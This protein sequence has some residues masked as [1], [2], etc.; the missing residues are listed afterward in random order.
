MKKIILIVTILFSTILI[1]QENY[2]YI[3]IP[4]QFPFFKEVDKYNLNSLTKSFFE[5]EGF[6][7]FFDSSDLPT[8]VSKNRCLALYVHAVENNS[9]FM[10]RIT[11]VV[12]DCKNNVLITSDEGSTREKDYDKAYNQ[13]M[14]A[15]LSSLKGK[16]K[17]KPESEFIENEGKSLPKKPSVLDSLIP[18][19][20]EII[21]G[22]KNLLFALPTEYGFKLVNATPSVIFELQKTSIT[23][24]F[25]AERGMMDNGIFYKKEDIW[26]YEYYNK[27]K[28]VIE[29]VEVK[30]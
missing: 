9:M 25:L 27:E 2:K 23:D 3:I 26:Y 19:P 15:A 22:N 5:T 20:K 24:L 12:K 28:L 11:V 17:F 7:A 4:S 29:K 30:F 10:T 1:A 21:E 13:A 16:L 14:R 8:E 18:A 6:T